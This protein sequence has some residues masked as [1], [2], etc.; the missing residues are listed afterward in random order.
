MSKIIEQDVEELHRILSELLDSSLLDLE[1]EASDCLEV[2]DQYDWKPKP[3]VKMFTYE[4]LLNKGLSGNLT[5][6]ELDEFMGL[7][8]R[9]GE[10]H[11]YLVIREAQ[12][13][14]DKPR[15]VQ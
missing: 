9:E 4:H 7:V 8:S 6:E 3:G 14:V 11:V 15:P 10:Y 13:L 5:V 2:F 12:M 1:K